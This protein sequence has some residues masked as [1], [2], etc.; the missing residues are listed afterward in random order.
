VKS[1]SEAKRLIEQGGVKV[2]GEKIS[3]INFLV[4]LENETLVQCGK[5]VFAKFINTK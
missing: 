5:R 3:D 1:R 4:S 2:N